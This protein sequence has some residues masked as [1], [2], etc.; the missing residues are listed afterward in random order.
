MTRC[1]ARPR[2][3]RPLPSAP[4]SANFSRECIWPDSDFAPFQPHLRGIGWWKSAVPK[5]ESHVPDDVM[6]VLAEELIFQDSF[7]RSAT[8]KNFPPVRSTPTCFATTC[9]SSTTRTGDR[10]GGVI[11]FYFAGC[12]IW[13]F[14]LAITI[15]DW[16][17]VEAQR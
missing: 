9:C 4:A 14:D 17:I 15:N 12:S 8:S 5:L 2:P 1:R 10:I 13:L 3:S 16:C 11:D 6:R 7:F